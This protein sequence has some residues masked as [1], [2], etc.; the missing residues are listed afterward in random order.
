MTIRR[1]ASFF[2]RFVGSIRRLNS[3]FRRFVG[4]QSLGFFFPSLSPFFRHFLG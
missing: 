1:L 3:S 4:Y 2:R